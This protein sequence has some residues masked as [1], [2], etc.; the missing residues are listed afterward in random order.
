MCD[1]SLE[2]YAS[3]KAIEGETLTTQRF[4][5]GTV[6]LI[7]KCHADVC[8]CMAPGTKLTIDKMSDSV[9]QVL[10]AEMTGPVE[11]EFVQLVTESKWA[12]RDCFKGPSGECV[13][14]NT[15]GA[16]VTVTFDIV[17]PAFM[18]E[19]ELMQVYLDPALALADV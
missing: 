1:Y 13:K 4:P 3:R 8:V 17:P 6:G 7:D 12:H 16:G 9:R 15:I 19:E 2:G 10:G 18:D 5:T 14:L 11:V